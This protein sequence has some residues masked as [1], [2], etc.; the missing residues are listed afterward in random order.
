MGLNEGYERA[1][2]ALNARQRQAVDQIDGPL[3]VIAGP[4]TGKTQLLSTRVARIL[5]VTDAQPQNILCLT[6]TESGAANM[7]ERLSRFIGRDA[8]N[9]QIST[10]HGFGSD[11]ISNN[12]QYFADERLEQPID[13]IGRYRLVHDILAKLPF[14]D[15][16]KTAEPRDVIS[17]ISDI[18]RGLLTSPDVRAIVLENDQTMRRVNAQL[19]DIFADFVR[20]PTKL[21]KARPYFTA[22]LQALAS[23]APEQPVNQAYGSVAIIAAHELQEALA[24]ADELGKGKPLT[25]WK[26]AWLEKDLENH[27]V[28]KGTYANRKLASMADVMDTYQ[29]QMREAGLYDFDDMILRPI[30][31]LKT[32]DD[33]RFTLQEKYLYILLDE[34]QDTNRAQA[35]L[36]HL[37]ADNPVHEGRPNVMAVGDDDQ[38][39][40]AFQGA[41]YSN[42]VDFYRAYRDTSV[43]NLS[44]NYRSHADIL[45]AG[46][47]IAEQISERVFHQF[48]GASKELIAANAKLREAHLERR[49]F[50]SDI[51]EYA[52][53]AERIA[54]V[55]ATGTNPS[56][57]AI[58]APKHK[59]LQAAVPLLQKLQ[60]PIR[61]QRS[62]NVLD[63]PLVRQLLTVAKLLVALGK[64]DAAAEQ[65]WPEVLSFPFWELPTKLVWQLSWR[66]SDERDQTRW[67][68]FLLEHEDKRLRDIAQLLLQLAGQQALT[69]CEQLIDQIVGTSPVEIPSSG[70]PAESEKLTSPLRAHYER[71]GDGA[72]YDMTA[73]LTILREAIR[74]RQ[75]ATSETFTLADLLQLVDDYELAG[76]KLA[77]TSPYNQAAEAVQL[78]SAHNAKGLEFEHVFLLSVTN[79]IWG[80]A[81][82]N[83]NMLAL[84]ANLAPVRHTGS[85]EDE[86]LRLLFVA[87]TRAKQ[88]LHLTSHEQTYSG[89]RTTRLKYLDE[90]EQ[91]DGSFHAHAFPERW[92]TVL[93]DDHEAPELPQLEAAWTSQHFVEHNRDLTPLLKERV[94][95][96]QISA[97]HLGSFCDLQY[98]GPAQFYINTILRFPS[99]GTASSI[100]G[101]AI[102]DTLEF[103]Q[104]ATSKQGTLPELTQIIAHFERLMRAGRLTP[105]ET[106]QL[107]DRGISALS[108]FMAARSHI[109]RPGDRAEQNFRRE[110]VFVGEAHMTGKIDRLE[111]DQEAKTITVVDYKTGKPHARHDK[112]DKKLHKYVQQLYCYKLLIEGS[113]TY[114][115]YTVTAGRLEFIEPDELG[116]IHHIDYEFDPAQLEET[117]ELLQAVYQH[118]IE[119]NFPDVSNYA[120]NIRGI[121]AFEDDLRAGTI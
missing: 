70:E 25:A 76:E 28:L 68:A 17:T 97:S 21:D 98:G 99:A 1:Y 77:N 62:E 66:V 51:A 46:T 108:A 19:L 42:M 102:H 94:T 91:E 106:E 116:K 67:A 33:L 69:S 121:R 112:S 45:S 111:I 119:L 89:K 85:T 118:I 115:G 26:D 78:M 40:Y 37:L 101:T 103:V 64:D 100:F 59:Y 79:D 6:F 57:I 110:G 60:V 13:T 11:I 109:F 107:I 73:Y 75:R 4:G 104:Q 86:R 105:H 88:G 10:Y 74:A 43:I 52:W 81:K 71:L 54:G 49:D 27:F 48:D 20:M 61:Y 93:H 3:L 24:A 16:L 2:A 44:E 113:T 87:I 50:Q 8:Y 29:T 41:Q 47:Y 38:A 84:P 56:E 39:I 117:R 7:R 72:L 23:S 12:G 58:L 9:V 15:P 5:E 65:Y 22:T 92:R 83:N 96:Y 30:H 34:Y 55:I 53:V 114:A 18:K 80:N 82:G 36:V 32:N 35:E 31:A 14:R 90:R 95:D 63:A 120:P